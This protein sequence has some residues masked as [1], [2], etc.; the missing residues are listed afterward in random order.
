[1][2]SDSLRKHEATLPR[3]NGCI[4]SVWLSREIGNRQG[5]AASLGNLGIIAN[6][7]GDLAEAERFHRECMAIMREIGNRYGEAGSLNNL[8]NIAQTRGDL[9]EAERLQRESLAI[10]KE[11]GDRHGGRRIH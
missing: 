4:E 8:G 10:K 7:R 6:T 1:M 3:R 9:A 2:A 11:I 5:E